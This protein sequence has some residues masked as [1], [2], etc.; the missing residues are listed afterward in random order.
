MS[1]NQPISEQFQR[2][3]AKWVDTEAAAKLLEETK[4]AYL[5]QQMQIHAQLPINRAEQIVKSSKPWVD[6][7]EKMVGAR[8][9]ANLDWVQVEYLKM[10]FQEW[11]SEE[12]NKRVEARL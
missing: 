12:A 4:S 7:I 1:D 2:A 8:R 10:K 5:S 9:Q 11:Q 6:Y 3:A